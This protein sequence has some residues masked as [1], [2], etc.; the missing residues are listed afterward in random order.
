MFSAR[1]HTDEP[2]IAC[3]RAYISKRVC[4]RVCMY[5]Q[6]RVFLYVTV[7]ACLC[8]YDCIYQFQSVCF[9]KCLSM[10]VSVSKC[11]CESV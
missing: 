5:K 1:L 4:V 3:D 8:M 2:K 11:V 10:T 6:G 7:C 9:C